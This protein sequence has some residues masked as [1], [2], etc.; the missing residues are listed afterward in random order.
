MNIIDHY[1]KN[2]A[3]LWALK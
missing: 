3:T 1:P 2:T